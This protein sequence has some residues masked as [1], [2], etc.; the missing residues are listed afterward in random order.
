M[1]SWPTGWTHPL[2]GRSVEDDGRWPRCAL[3]WLAAVTHEYQFDSSSIGTCCMA[4]VH[5]SPS[6]AYLIGYL[7]GGGKLINSIVVI[8]CH[9]F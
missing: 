2:K 4:P 6:A 9:S 3:Q 5:L 7:V 8:G 1:V